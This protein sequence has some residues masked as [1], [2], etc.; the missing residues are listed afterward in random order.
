[1]PRRACRHFRALEACG[2]QD[3]TER[4]A[5]LPD[6]EVKLSA[7]LAPER[8]VHA[9]GA[10]D[11]GGRAAAGAATEAAVV[12]ISARPMAG[13]M[14]RRD[15][16]EGS[17]RRDGRDRPTSTSRRADDAD[18]PLEPVGVATGWPRLRARPVPVVHRLET[19]PVPMAPPARTQKRTC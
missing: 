13:G 6:A 1:M 10:P 3:F 2:G 5:S 14:G 7:H 8:G 17:V 12:W 11:L 18:G 16:G 19:G 9:A 15:R 4:R